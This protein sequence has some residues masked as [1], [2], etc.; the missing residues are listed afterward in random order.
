M[1]VVGDRKI[2]TALIFNK[3]AGFVTS[4]SGKNMYSQQYLNSVKSLATYDRS[5]LS[6]SFLVHAKLFCILHCSV[7]TTKLDYIRKVVS[8][9]II[10]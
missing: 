10:L 6:S 8:V 4:I 3:I 9:F 7:I 2:R 5:Y 1:T